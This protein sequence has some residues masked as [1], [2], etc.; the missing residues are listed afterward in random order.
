MTLRATLE[1]AHPSSEKRGTERRTLRLL[2]SVKRSS[3]RG[4]Q[5]LVHDVS[6]GGMLI[7]SDE[8]LDIGE[9]LSVEL[10]RSGSR[11]AEIVWTSGRFYGCRF[12]EE[13]SSAVVS[14]ALLKAIPAPGELPQQSSGEE[15][16]PARLT[17]LREARGL[18]MEQL[19]DRLRVSRQAVWYWETGHR[20]PR[21]GMLKRIASQLNV[22][23][24]ELLLLNP[25]Q[26]GSSKGTEFAA[27]KREIAHRLR[28]SPD[29]VKILV[30]L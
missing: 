18:S 4:T 26:A 15:D 29:Q 1:T 9:S 5:A 12:T 16:F 30:E 11:E 8:S 14:A 10:P 24:G 6:T 3:R 21:A 7:E 25:R 17:S 19:A 28:I 22:A 20:L 23:E 27:W 2:T 13:L